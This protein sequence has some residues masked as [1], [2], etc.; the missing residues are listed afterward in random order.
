MSSEVKR[1][2][3]YW[4]DWDPA[5][6][7]E[8]KGQRPALVIQND[9]GNK[10]SSTTIVATCSTKFTKSYPFQVFVEA[11]ESGLPDDCIIDLGQIITVDK[12]RL[13]RK[14]GKL[15]KDKMHEVNKALQISL[16]L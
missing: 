8:Q 13:L 2:E 4:I 11:R 12:S 7:S 6:G 10:Y 16:A 9:V 3:I 14:C 15:S 1:G 5:R